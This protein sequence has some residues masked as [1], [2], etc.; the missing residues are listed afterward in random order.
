VHQIHV[1]DCLFVCLFICFAMLRLWLPLQH[2]VHRNLF[3]EVSTR[4][5]DTARDIF[6]QHGWQR[7]L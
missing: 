5:E 4:L 7:D 6:F 2:V 1:F 3:T